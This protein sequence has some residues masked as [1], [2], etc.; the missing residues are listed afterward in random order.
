MRLIPN[1][2]P[3]Q[4]MVADN[5]ALVCA[6]SHEKFTRG[7]IPI[8]GRAH[9]NN[10]ALLK[11]AHLLPNTLILIILGTIPTKWARR[12]ECALKETHPT[13]FPAKGV[14]NTVPKYRNSTH[15]PVI[16]QHHASSYIWRMRCHLTCTLTSII[17][18]FRA[19]HDVHAYKSR[20]SYSSL[21]KA[22][23]DKSALSWLHERIIS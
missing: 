2:K 7:F 10:M 21:P 13:S 17:R 3:N 4:N 19:R 12:T 16:T 9:T 11:V 1:V 18:G 8:K 20:I 14:A 5:M 15:V 6:S 22:E 23:S